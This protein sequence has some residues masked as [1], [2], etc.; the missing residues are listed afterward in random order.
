MTDRGDTPHASIE[1]GEGRETAA[2]AR[3]RLVDAVARVRRPS[4]EALF[5]SQP[6]QIPNPP[7][8]HH[9]RG[10]PHLARKTAED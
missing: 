3:E 5:S 1:T 9:R 6:R 4:H 2:S 10:A 8:A 7:L